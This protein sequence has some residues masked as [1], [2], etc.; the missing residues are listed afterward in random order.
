MWTAIRSIFQQCLLFLIASMLCPNLSGIAQETSEKEMPKETKK[1]E[2]QEE[3]EKKKK[4]DHYLVLTGGD[5]YTITGPVLEKTDILIKNGVIEE[6][7]QSLE[8]PE[9]SQALDVT[10]MRVYP[11]LI[12]VASSGI[13]GREPPENSTDLFDLDLLLALAG[14]LT[15][16]VTGNTAAK[17]T[18]G[19]T[20]G[21]VLRR[22]LFSNISFSR[23]SPQKR[24]ALK[25]DLDR[26]HPKPVS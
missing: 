1:S 14:G 12:A 24:Q 20:E 16:V 22:N 10:G 7:G 19:T 17:I 4:E 3:K 21:M 18:Y 6:I 5:L 23:R 11:G 2:Q 8:V 9:K 15:T 26:V 13:L 25:Q